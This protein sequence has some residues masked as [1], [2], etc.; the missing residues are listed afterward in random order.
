MVFRERA[1]YLLLCSVVRAWP[2]VLEPGLGGTCGPL[3]SYLALIA[4]L[5]VR[6]F[7]LFG[8]KQVQKV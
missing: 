4:V 2:G 1:P 7:G 8:R 5:F 6:S 3:A